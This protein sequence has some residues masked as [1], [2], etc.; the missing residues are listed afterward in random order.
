MSSLPDLVC[1]AVS[2]MRRRLTD[3]RDGH[4]RSHDKNVEKNDGRNVRLHQLPALSHQRSRQLL[5]DLRSLKGSA[6]QHAREDDGEGGEVSLRFRK[7][8]SLTAGAKA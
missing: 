1:I 5:D 7:D 3:D 4:E 6:G 2:R 8:V